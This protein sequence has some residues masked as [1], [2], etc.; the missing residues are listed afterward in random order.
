M[1]GLAIVI[2]VHNEERAVSAAPVFFCDLLD[3]YPETEVIPADDGPAD[4]KKS[5]QNP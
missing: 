2:P 3:K 5:E 1:D 4:C